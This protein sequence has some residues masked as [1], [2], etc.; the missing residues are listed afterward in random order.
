MVRVEYLEYEVTE[1]DQRVDPP[2]V[3]LENSVFRLETARSVLRFNLKVD[4]EEVN[5]AEAT[6][7]ELLR[8]FQA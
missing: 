5:Q 6:V 2:L 3:V 8:S 7:G 4:F 1:G